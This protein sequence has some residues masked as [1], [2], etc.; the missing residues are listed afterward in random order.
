[1]EDVLWENVHHFSP[2]NY[3]ILSFALASRSAH[4][5]A[6]GWLRWV[7]LSP[8]MSSARLFEASRKEFLAFLISNCFSFSRCLVDW[9][10][11]HVDSTVRDDV[12]VDVQGTKRLPHLSRRTHRAIS[13]QNYW[14]ATGQGSFGILPRS[15]VLAR[16][17]VIRSGGVIPGEFGGA[18]CDCP[19]ILR[20]SRI[21]RKCSAI[22]A[23]KSRRNSSPF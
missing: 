14:R 18:K 9:V 20:R 1:M 13:E 5:D 8:L 23:A 22:A 10:A 6:C 11:E 3:L 21:S 12:V 4:S 19:M 17:V 15:N 2:P 7:C 16:L